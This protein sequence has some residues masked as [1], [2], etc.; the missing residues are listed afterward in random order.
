[1]ILNKI[2]IVTV[3]RIRPMKVQKGKIIKKELFL[4]I[5]IIHINPRMNIML[6][7]R[8]I[9]IHIEIINFLMILIIFQI[10]HL[11]YLKKYLNQKIVDIIIIIII[12]TIIIIVGQI[13]LITMK[14]I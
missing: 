8:I 13:I 14:K 11:L 1:M 5:I 12:I 3:K 10:I 2:I 9:L 6:P 7:L 4:N